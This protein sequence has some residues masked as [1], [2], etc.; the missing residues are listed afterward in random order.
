MFLIF[1]LILLPFVNSLRWKLGTNAE[2]CQSDNGPKLLKSAVIP[3]MRLGAGHAL[4]NV[5]IDDSVGNYLL[6]SRNEC[7]SLGFPEGLG[8]LVRTSAR[9]H[10]MELYHN[11]PAFLQDL[12]VPNKSVVTEI[13]VMCDIQCENE[14]PRLGLTV[15]AKDFSLYVNEHRE[16]YCHSNPVEADDL[17][18]R[19]KLSIMIDV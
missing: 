10:T 11:S 19:P 2:F 18:K 8:K 17:G 4:R 13:R 12:D 6:L 3:Y 15:F 5:K 7:D 9:N 16:L 14:C 1:V